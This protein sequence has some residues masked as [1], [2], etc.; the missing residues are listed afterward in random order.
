MKKIGVEILATKTDLAV[1]LGVE[2][3]TVAKLIREKKIP[4]AD[5]RFGTCDVWFTKKYQTVVAM[6]ADLKRQRLAPRST[7]GKRAAK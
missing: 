5:A 1:A 2:G 4:E 7:G 3:Q 6:S